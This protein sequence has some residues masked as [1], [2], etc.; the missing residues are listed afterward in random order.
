MVRPLP[1]GALAGCGVA[2]GREPVY[3]EFRPGDV[4]H[5]LADV[6]AARELLGYC[7]TH[8]LA[9]GLGAAMPWY[10]RNLS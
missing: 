5:S 6:S 4:R 1:G 7:P 3:R 10:V 9:A 2:Y 8:D